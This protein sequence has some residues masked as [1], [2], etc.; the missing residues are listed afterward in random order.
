MDRLQANKR[1][2]FIHALIGAANYV[3]LDGLALTNGRDLL[4]D[5][6][7]ETKLA[8]SIAALERL[9]YSDFIHQ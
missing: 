5:Q 3:M 4:R 2:S 1:T 8:Y 6:L 9:N 7:I